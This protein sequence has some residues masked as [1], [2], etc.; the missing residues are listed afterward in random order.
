MNEPVELDSTHDALYRDVLLEHTAEFPVLGVPVFFQSNSPRVID[1]VDDAFGF[2]NALEGRDDLVSPERFR[3]QLIVHEGDEGNTAH[4]P[5]TY[6]LP[7]RDRVFLGTP[8]SVGCADLRRRDAV[9]YVTPSLVADIAHFRYGFLE[10]LTLFLVTSLDRRPLHAAA[11]VRGDKALLL[12]APGGVGKSTLVYAATRRG[13]KVLSDDTVYIQLNPKLRIWGLPTRVHLPVEAR[14]VFPELSDT[15]VTLIA[16]G[17][18][19]IAIDAVRAGSAADSPFVERAGLCVMS[20]DGS[21]TVVES[22]SPAELETALVSYPE[23]GFDRFAETIGECIAKLAA[24]GGWRLNVGGKLDQVV[25]AVE[26]I[27]EE[28]AAG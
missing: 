11:L 28:M 21:E 17:E 25:E 4:A 18:E 6:R 19:K 7:D 12:A 24:P 23:T 27:F 1:A 5:I 9:A 14:T 10:T 22:L 16:N 15:T 3:V 8:G 13:L 20:R 2:W 26:Q